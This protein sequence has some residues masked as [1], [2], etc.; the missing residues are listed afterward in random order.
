MEFERTIKLFEEE[1]FNILKTKSILILGMGGVGSFACEAIARSGINNIIIVD[2]DVVDI[3]NINRQLIALHSTIGKSKVE[4][5]KEPI[6]DINKNAV[7]TTYHQF[8]NFDTKDQIWDNKIDFVIDCIDT[9]TFKIDIIKECLSRKIP[10]ISSM[11][12]ANKMHPELLEIADIKDTTY[13]KIAKVIRLKLKKER[14]YGKVPVVYSKETSD[15]TFI[16]EEGLPSNSF[17]PSSAGLLAASYA[18]NTLLSEVK[19]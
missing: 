3:T 4:L 13:D 15:K 1:K 14:I 18:I 12:Q 11:G 2:K 9:I 19:L 6:L 16:K 7:V 8:Y 10:F 17:V 5:M